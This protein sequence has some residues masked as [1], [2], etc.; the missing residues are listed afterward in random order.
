MADRVAPRQLSARARTV[1]ERAAAA[2]AVRPARR[3]HPRH[4]DTATARLLLGGPSPPR[5]PSTLPGRGRAA[6]RGARPTAVRRRRR[7]AAV[8]AQAAVHDVLQF[9]PRERGRRVQTA[10]RTDPIRRR[11]VRRR[12]PAAGAVR[13]VQREAVHQRGRQPRPTD[14]ADLGPRVC[15]LKRRRRQRPFLTLIIFSY[16]PILH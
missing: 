12:Q 13:D 15:R 4:A 8:R 11:Q 7:A 14:D 5:R 9:C 16:R 2:A 3:R 6:V 1:R 10:G